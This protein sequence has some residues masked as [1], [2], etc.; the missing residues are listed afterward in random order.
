[1]NINFGIVEQLKTK[2]K[3]RKQAYADRALEEIRVQLCNEI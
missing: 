1:M 3:D 2:K